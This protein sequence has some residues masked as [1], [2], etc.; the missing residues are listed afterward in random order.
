MAVAHRI[1][2][3][4]WHIIRDGGVYQ[5]LGGSHYDRLHPDRSA[6]RLIRRLQQI[7]FDVTVQPIPATDHVAVASAPCAPTRSRPPA[8]GPSVCRKCARLRIPCI[9]ARP[10]KHARQTGAPMNTAT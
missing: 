2:I 1:L 4:C 8:A 5:E 6:R 3:I 7:G 10:N 9:H